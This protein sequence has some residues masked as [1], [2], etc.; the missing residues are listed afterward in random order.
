M[1][2]REFRSSLPQHSK[3]FKCSKRRLRPR[4]RPWTQ[5]TAIEARTARI[6]PD[7]LRQ[8]AVSDQP[9]PFSGE[10]TMPGQ[11]TRSWKMERASVTVGNRSRP[12]SNKYSRSDT[13]RRPKPGTRER[14]WVGAYT[15]GDG[16]K[17]A[18]YYRSI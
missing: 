17:V 3:N 16:Q 1:T 14:V 6:R 10:P 8:P 7:L 5:R 13:S 15:R 12:R 9:N 4:R 18:G 2:P 11:S